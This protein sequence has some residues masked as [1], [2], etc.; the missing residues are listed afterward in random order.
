MRLIITSCIAT[1]VLFLVSFTSADYFDAEYHKDGIKKSVTFNA[2][3][4]DMLFF[5]DTDNFAVVITNDGKKDFAY[6]FTSN[7][8]IGKNFEVVFSKRSHSQGIHSIKDIK[9][10]QLKE[11]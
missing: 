6:D 7:D 8:L 9:S 11:E 5:T 3:E 10:M 2:Y 1:L 4:G